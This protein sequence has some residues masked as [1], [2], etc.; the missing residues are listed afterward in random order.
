MHF[1]VFVRQGILDKDVKQVLVSRILFKIPKFRCNCD[2]N[3]L[4]W[5]E[6][7]GYLI[8]KNTLPVSEVRLGDTGSN[9]KDQ[10]TYKVGALECY[11]EI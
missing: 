7:G 1:V 5:R 9:K 11:G 8:D 3:D 2:S 4:Q 10:G 6:D